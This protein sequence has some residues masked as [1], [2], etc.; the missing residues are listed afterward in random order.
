ME[1]I[2]KLKD[3]SRWSNS[4]LIRITEKQNK[5]NGEKEIIKELVIKCPTTEGPKVFKGLLST[6]QNL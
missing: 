6:Q 4:Q 1:K 5:E 3:Q 2:R